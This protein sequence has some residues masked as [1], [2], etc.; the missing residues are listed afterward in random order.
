MSRRD[1]GLFTVYTDRYVNGE[2]KMETTYFDGK[3]KGTDAWHENGLKWYE[4]TFKGVKRVGK[5]TEWHTNGQKGAEGT[6]R[7]D[8]RVGKWTTWYPNGQKFNEGSFKN[9][10]ECGTSNYWD[11][12][13]I[14]PNRGS[15]TDSP[16]LFIS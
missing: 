12:N 4:H 16:T 14:S 8:K 13:G 1:D 5:W 6:Y 10:M 3:L 15:P 7:D 11:K 9:S 2:K